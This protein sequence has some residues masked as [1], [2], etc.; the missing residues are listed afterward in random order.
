MKKTVDVSHKGGYDCWSGDIE[1][2]CDKKMKEFIFAV[3]LGSKTSNG[4]GC[5]EV[6]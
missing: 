2:E 6:K 3:G 4:F 1:V 5:L